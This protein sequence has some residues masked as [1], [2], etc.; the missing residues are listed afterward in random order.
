MSRVDTLII[1]GD[2]NCETNEPAM[3]DFC[4][5]YSLKKL[6]TEPTLQNNQ[7][8]ETGLSDHHKMTVTVKNLLPKTISYS[9]KV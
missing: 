1:L 4:N 7:V 8:V 9:F 5:I 3:K 6:I 2:F